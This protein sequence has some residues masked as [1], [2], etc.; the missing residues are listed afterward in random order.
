MC[1]QIVAE[2]NA[3]KNMAASV[4]ADQHPLDNEYRAKHSWSHPCRD[5]GDIYYNIKEG[6][7]RELDTLGIHR[8]NYTL[9]MMDIPYGLCLPLANHDDSYAWTKEDVVKVIR[10]F[11]LL[12]TADQ[13]RVVIMHS[14]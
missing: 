8:R 3:L 9:L 11:K 4:S 6:D 12:T 14:R 5:F 10:K 13:F 2:K 1:S 7:A